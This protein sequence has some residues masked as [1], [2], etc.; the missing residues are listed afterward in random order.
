MGLIV[1]PTM[2]LSE[3]LAR[4]QALQLSWVVRGGIWCPV[5]LS[6][7]RTWPNPLRRLTLEPERSGETNYR[8]LKHARSAGKTGGKQGENRGNRGQ[9]G[10]FLIEAE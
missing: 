7:Q 10:R 4:G 6:A 2:V 5:R 3:T 8:S 1:V 9:T